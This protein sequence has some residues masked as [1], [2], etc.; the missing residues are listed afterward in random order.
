MNNFK[1]NKRNKKNVDD[2]I[3][4][5]EVMNVISD[6]IGILDKLDKSDFF[7]LEQVKNLSTNKQ[8]IETFKNNRAIDLDKLVDFDLSNIDKEIIKEWENKEINGLSV[9]LIIKYVHYIFYL[10][11][12]VY[13][14]DI[15]NISSRLIEEKI[16]VIEKNVQKKSTAICTKSRQKTAAKWKSQVL[17]AWESGQYEN[18]TKCAKAESQRL[19]IAERTVY[20][21]LKTAQ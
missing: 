10:D 1:F 14:N 12:L 9:L 8:F 7:Q 19:G 4:R 15:Q 11:H 16:E 6:F 3:K 5:Y 21:Y 17:I 20:D 18:K 2:S 13:K